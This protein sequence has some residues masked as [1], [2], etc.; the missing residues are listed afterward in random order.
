MK[1]PHIICLILTIQICLLSCKDSI[2]EVDD[3]RNYSPLEIGRFHIYN[4]IEEN[5]FSGVSQPTI[6]NYQEKEQITAYKGDNLF[7]VALYRR[8]N[9]N[10][11]W[12]KDKEF[13]IQLYPDRLIKNIDNKNYVYLTFPIQRFYEWNGNIYNDLEEKSYRYTEVQLR[14]S[15]TTS[16]SK[17]QSKLSKTTLTSTKTSSDLIVPSE[18]LLIM[19]A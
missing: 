17:K 7:I 1:R 12:T 14:L 3:P 19:S 2:Q 8:P 4:V 5:Y 6:L 11:S 16:C 13:S 9:V 10:A 18:S 15:S